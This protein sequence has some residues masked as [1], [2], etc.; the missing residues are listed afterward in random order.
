[1][2]SPAADK[3]LS[4]STDVRGTDSKAVV[5]LVMFVVFS[6]VAS[7]ISNSVDIVLFNRLTLPGCVADAGSPITSNYRRCIS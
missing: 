4:A 5:I 7:Y 1:M 2:I 3:A 6:S